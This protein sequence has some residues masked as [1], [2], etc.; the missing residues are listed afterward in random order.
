MIKRTVLVN[1]GYTRTALF[2][3]FRAKKSFLVPALEP[4]TVADAIVRQVLAGESG[5]VLLPEFFGNL[6]SALR[7]WP[8]WCM[9]VRG[10]ASGLKPQP[11]FLFLPTR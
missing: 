1:Q 10:G 2:D 3:G 7:A 8:H 6:L 11:R 5:H 4:E 9:S